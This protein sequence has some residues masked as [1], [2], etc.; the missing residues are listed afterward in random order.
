[1]FNLK[2]DLVDKIKA[3]EIVGKIIGE[4]H[5][6]PIYGQWDNAGDIPFD[7]LP[8]QFVRENISEVSFVN[9]RKKN[10]HHW[11]MVSTPLSNPTFPLTS[12]IPHLMSL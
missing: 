10:A 7:A 8:E 6:V 5:I 11:G 3:K 4:E 12:F 1:M 2:K 9:L